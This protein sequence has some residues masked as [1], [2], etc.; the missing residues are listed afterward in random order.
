MRARLP[1]ILSATALLV[2][3][4]GATPLGHA[5]GRVIHAV[6]PFAKTAGYAKLAGNAAQ[7][8][9]RK[10]TLS[11]APRTIPVVGPNGKLPASIGAVGPQG[12]TGPRGPAGPAGPRGGA[13]E[14]G[15]PGMSGYEIVTAV[16]ALDANDSKSATAQCPAGKKVVGGTG[17]WVGF[18][19][20]NI[21]EGIVGGG[22][23][24]V[25]SGYELTPNSQPWGV[26][27]QAICVN[28]AP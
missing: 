10:S 7:L 26:Q 17:T 28:I 19:I 11:G 20:E 21:N 12:A 25:A 8:N 1:I 23:A 27:V 18:G 9:G 13:G 2:A 24:W 22:T 5:A 3:V 6:P 4:F 16:S 15:A 14:D